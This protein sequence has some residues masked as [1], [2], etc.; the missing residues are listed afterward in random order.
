MGA[1]LRIS[2]AVIAR[3][4]SEQRLTPG[5]SRRL[6]DSPA[7]LP[8]CPAP[9]PSIDRVEQAA[10]LIA[11]D[12][13][14]G[15]GIGRCVDQLGLDACAPGLSSLRP[16]CR[17]S[18]HAFGMPVGGLMP[19]VHVALAAEPKAAVHMVV[20]NALAASGAQ[21][22]ARALAVALVALR[23]VAC[24]APAPVGL[25]AGC[26]HRGGRITVRFAAL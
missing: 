4:P 14:C 8:A 17:V 9:T 23:F 18:G 16:E 25:A 6:E 26:W 10:G 21:L 19:G 15:P 2:P 22:A 13:Q 20:R 24:A 3:H 1:R 12:G 5:V 7:R 11:V